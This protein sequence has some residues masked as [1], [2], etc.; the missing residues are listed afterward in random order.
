MTFVIN[1]VELATNTVIPRRI[2]AESTEQ[3]MMI[4]DMMAGNRYVWYV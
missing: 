3:A 1:F 2:M 4:A